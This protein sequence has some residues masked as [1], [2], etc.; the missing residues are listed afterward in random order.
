MPTPIEL[1]KEGE[2]RPL[3]MLHPET[4]E[5][6]T[7]VST[8]AYFFDDDSSTIRYITYLDGMRNGQSVTDVQGLSATVPT[9]KQPLH[10]PKFSGWKR[11]VQRKIP[12]GQ[13]IPERPNR[14]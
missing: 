8:E 11:A 12:L 2:H 14:L 13:F 1:P 6:F 3:L 10:G 5:P 7:G 4:K 9:G